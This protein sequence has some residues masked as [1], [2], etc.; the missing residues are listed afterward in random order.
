MC[1]ESLD[2]VSVSYRISSHK[3]RPKMKRHLQMLL[4]AV[5]IFFVCW[6]AQITVMFR[7]MLHF[8]GRNSERFPKTKV[9][10]CYHLQLELGFSIS[11]E[12]VCRHVFRLRTSY[13]IQEYQTQVWS[14]NDDTRLLHILSADPAAP[15]TKDT[16]QS[17]SCG[18]SFCSKLCTCR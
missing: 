12:L 7:I 1:F 5:K 8:R 14:K 9:P 2:E 4:Q 16:F 3:A 18:A 10:A 11:T 15:E 17:A 13:W 6:S